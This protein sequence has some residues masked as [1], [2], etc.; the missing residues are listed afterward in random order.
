M[1]AEYLLPEF[2]SPRQAIGDFFQPICEQVRGGCTQLLD[3]SSLESAKRVVCLLVFLD[4]LKQEAEHVVEQQRVMEALV[5]VTTQW[6]ISDNAV[7]PELLHISAMRSLDDQLPAIGVLATG[8]LSTILGPF[9]WFPGI[10]IV[11]EAMMRRTQ[12][13]EGFPEAL[14]CGLTLAKSMLQHHLIRMVYD[15]PRLVRLDDWYK[16]DDCVDLSI[17]QNSIAD[18]SYSEHVFGEFSFS[19]NSQSVESK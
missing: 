4:A 19:E 7:G 17:L 3:V 2:I 5:L 13:W 11:N 10:L 9:A 15:P 16:V 8:A 12:K 14:P 1:C 6:K 18:G